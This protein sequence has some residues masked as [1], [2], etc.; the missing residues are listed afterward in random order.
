MS[1]YCAYYIFYFYFFHLVCLYTFY[2]FLCWD[3][4]SIY[5]NGVTPTSW[6]IFILAA[7][8]D[9]TNLSLCVTLALGPVVLSF[10]M[11]VKIFLIY[12]TP[13]NSGLYLGH[14]EDG[15]I[16]LWIS[17]RYYR[18]CWHFCLSQQWTWF[19][20]SRTPCVGCGSNAS[21][22]FE[23]LAVPFGLGLRVYPVA[24]PAAGQ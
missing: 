13:S 12:C 14:F 1:L 17:L 2:I 19:G 4:L 7:L 3:C 15:V 5:G 10:P 18:K 6:S 21:P 23:A 24:G 20:S 9:V 11:E 8:Q 16:R 22:F